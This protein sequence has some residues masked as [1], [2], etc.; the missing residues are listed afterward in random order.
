MCALN[1]NFDVSSQDVNHS[2]LDERGINSFQGNLISGVNMPLFDLNMRD[3][4]VQ[5]TQEEW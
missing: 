5:P 3:T 4:V 2:A 1:Q